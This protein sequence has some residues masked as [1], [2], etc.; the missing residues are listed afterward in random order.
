M[1]IAQSSLQ[2]VTV[3]S[4]A[5]VVLL[6]F[7]TGPGLAELRVRY[8]TPAECEE[9]GG[10]ATPLPESSGPLIHCWVD[11]EPSQS[12]PAV[13]LDGTPTPRKVD[14]GP[15]TKVTRELLETLN[16]ETKKD[17]EA[18][19][20]S[21]DSVAKKLPD[22]VGASD[23]K[24]S[25]IEKAV[26][27]KSSKRLEKTKEK[28]AAVGAMIATKSGKRAPAVCPSDPQ[29]CISVAP[30]SD[31]GRYLRYKFVQGCDG[32]LIS[33]QYEGCDPVSK[34]KMAWI[35]D[36]NKSETWMLEDRIKYPEP[37]N[38]TCTTQF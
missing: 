35:K 21:S 20:R 30:Q 28:L 2:H 15:A 25:T 26:E 16:P 13:I 6:L 17:S 22:P 4:S 19:T 11:E 3:K 7:Q 12:V 24:L 10:A 8:M 1:A 32:V 9:L 36:M 29:S 33:F 38:V 31:Q 23:H 34:C 14:E 5:V 27:A 18:P 37:F